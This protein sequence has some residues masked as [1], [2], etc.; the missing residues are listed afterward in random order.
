MYIKLNEVKA[1]SSEVDIGTDIAE[2]NETF[3]NVNKQMEKKQLSILKPFPPGMFRYHNLICN[4]SLRCVII[5]KEARVE[6][7]SLDVVKCHTD[8]F[9]FNNDTSHLI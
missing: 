3:E 6:H 5:Y 9:S 2:Y 7:L 1:C 4:V 8:M